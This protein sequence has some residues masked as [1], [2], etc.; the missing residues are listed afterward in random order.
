MTKQSVTAK[1]V[2]DSAK[3]QVV[4]QKGPC[5]H[6]DDATVTTYN[7]KCHIIEHQN[8]KNKY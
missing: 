8:K 4:K 7:Y 1:Y 3:H 2:T 5:S 6:D